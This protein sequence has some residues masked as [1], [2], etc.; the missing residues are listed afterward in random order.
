MR[1]IWRFFQF[2]LK[3]VYRKSTIK[4]P[5]ACF[6]SYNT[7]DFIQQFDIR[8]EVWAQNW[9]GQ[10]YYSHTYKTYYKKLK[11]TTPIHDLTV[12][13]DVTYVLLKQ[14][15]VKYFA[16]RNNQARSNDDT[17]IPNMI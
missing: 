8:F 17:V 14:G 15:K 10:D 7:A 3:V 9:S 16:S 4:P 6:K 5:R 12:G 1:P 11:I 13:W 2:K